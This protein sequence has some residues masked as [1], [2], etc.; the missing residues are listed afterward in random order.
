MAPMFESPFSYRFPP[1]HPYWRSRSP[2]WWSPVG[3]QVRQQVPRL[4]FGIPLLASR[5]RYLRNSQ[6]SMRFSNFNEFWRTWLVN[7]Q[8]NGLW[9]Y[10]GVCRSILNDNVL[11]IFPEAWYMYCYRLL[12][13]NQNMTTRTCL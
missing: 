9:V 3:F 13:Y 10:G 11:N 1:L 12:Y 8:K 2:Y 7:L 6:T 5:C 4:L